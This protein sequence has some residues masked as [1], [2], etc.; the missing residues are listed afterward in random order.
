MMVHHETVERPIDLS[1]II[2]LSLEYSHNNMP[3]MDL[4]TPRMWVNEGCDIE[5]DIIPAMKKVME[6]KKGIT[7]YK[8]FNNPVYTAR[9]LRRVKDKAA[10]EL[11]AIPIEKII[12][13]YQFK[14]RMELPLSEHELKVLSDYEN[15]NQYV[16]ASE[17]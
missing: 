11:A 4:Q 1:K 16:V 9:D 8:Y 12:Q 6:R 5:L 10:A 13:S 2:A 17:A 15:K 3:F 7:C 14:R